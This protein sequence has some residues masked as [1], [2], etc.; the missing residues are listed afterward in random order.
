MTMLKT[1]E[2]QTKMAAGAPS[3]H[4]IAYPK[5]ETTGKKP[6]ARPVVEIR[7]NSLRALCKY[8]QQV[9]KSSPLQS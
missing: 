4:K 2:K 6:R 7:V 8:W 3:Q 5:N 1:D 9:G